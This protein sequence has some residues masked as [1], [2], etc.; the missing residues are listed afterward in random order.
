MLD[1][2]ADTRELDAQCREKFGLTEDIMMENAAA[3]LEEAVFES[4]GGEA[5]GALALVLCGSGNNGADGYAL[6]RRLC[7][8]GACVVAVKVSEPKSELCVAQCGRAVLC[9]C[10]V[11]APDGAAEWLGGGSYPKTVVVD[12]IFGSGF[13]GSVSEDVASL[14]CKVNDLDAFRIACDVP[15]GL[16][17]LG[18]AY[19]SVF[20]ADKTVVMGALKLALFSDCAKDAVGEIVVKN[21]GVSRALF[22]KCSKNGAVAK[23]LEKKD[24]CLPYRKKQNVH[25]GTYGH[26]VVAVGEKTGAAVLAAKAAFA[27][28]SGLVT[29]VG[30]KG[31]EQ[32]RN[33]PFELMCGDSMPANAT[34][35]AVGMGLGRESGAMDSFCAW[36]ENNPETS[37]VLDAD[38]FYSEK[39]CG[40]LE[41]SVIS[42]RKTVLT[43]HPKEFSVILEKC[44]F[45]S[46]STQDVVRERINLVRNFCNKYEGTV[47]LLKG[48]DVLIGQS[49]G[50]RCGLYVNP[51]GCNALAKGGSGDVLSGLVLALLAQGYEA[52]DAAITASL[53]H[54]FASKSFSGN[55]FALTPDDLISCVKQNIM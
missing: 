45:G 6:A 15:T 8:S 20:V 18:N 25:K 23:L 40:L 4:L 55:N 21:L 46:F 51:Y 50:G 39:I 48:A 53:S 49:T 5:S 33:I 43:P 2:F 16:D 27:F 1:I 10:T 29:L 26:A 30:K 54:S 35:L 7:G 52:L 13:H 14:L 44:G 41:K 24:M 47:L 11:V 9:G 37:L 22:E 31:F 17:S 42:K 32:G 36:L 28:G 3:A 34:A 12:C 38:A 19:G